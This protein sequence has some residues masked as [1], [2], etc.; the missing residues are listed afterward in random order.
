MPFY[1]LSFSSVN[2]FWVSLLYFTVN[3]MPLGFGLLVIHEK[4]FEGVSLD[5]G[6]L[7]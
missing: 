6:K 1:D 5:V 2:V 7:R 4:Q 3:L